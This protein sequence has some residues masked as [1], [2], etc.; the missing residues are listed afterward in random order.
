MFGFG[1]DLS[2][3][4]MTL[5]VL[6]G[7]ALQAQ[8]AKVAIVTNLDNVDYKNSRKFFEQA[9]IKEA[10]ARNV[11]VEFVYVDGQGNKENFIAEVKK[12]EP[13]VD[14]FYT[15]GTPNA[16][17]MKEAGITKPVLFNLIAGPVG[18][19][20]VNSLEV[21]GTN[22]TGVH[23]AVPEERQLRAML[24]VLPKIKKV[25]FLFTGSN[26][27]SQ[28]AINKWKT[29]LTK[30]PEMKSEDF[31]IPDAAVDNMDAV[32]EVVKQAIG[33]VDVLITPADGVVTKFGEAILKL[34]GEN[35]IPVYAA[36]SVLVPKGA[37]VSLGFDIP[38]LAKLAAPQALEIISGKS[39]TIMP[40]I[41][42][43][44]YRLIINLKMAQK[45]KLDIP[46]EAIKTASEV[47]KE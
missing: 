1:K 29:E 28:G 19:G 22:F 21:S 4:L 25:G 26:P 11:A 18:A 33:K 24:L 12:I 37:L 38:E 10:G 47:I 20:L 43:P 36:A 15:A 2:R 41:T 46:M 30:Y 8:A 7:F 6:F 14:V 32:L 9:L 31:L 3:I 39:P 44:Q 23:C 17:A 27:S 42:Y 45:M 40:V 5:M 13:T 16:V 34:A 35:N